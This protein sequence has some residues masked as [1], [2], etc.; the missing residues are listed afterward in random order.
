[1]GRTGHLMAKI[2][3]SVLNF[4]AFRS[5][6]KAAGFLKSYSGQ[7]MPYQVF[8]LRLCCPPFPR[9]NEFRSASGIQRSALRVKHS[10]IEC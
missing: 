5:F 2:W 6:L 7:A 1:M 8:L 3:A 10:S 4:P 9:F